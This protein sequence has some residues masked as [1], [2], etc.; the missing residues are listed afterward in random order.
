M[1]WQKYFSDAM[2][3]TQRKVTGKEMI[4]VYAP[5]YL[6]KLSVVVTNYTLTPEGKM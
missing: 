6:E 3:S 5:E 1:S 2:R 4:V